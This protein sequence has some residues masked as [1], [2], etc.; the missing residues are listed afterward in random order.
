ML[1]VFWHREYCMNVC[2]SQQAHG[3][4][5]ILR[6]T[7]FRFRYYVRRMER[8]APAQVVCGAYAQAH[9]RA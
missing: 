8:K 5:N 1:K 4:S 2:M 7:S 9:A 6:Y 3:R